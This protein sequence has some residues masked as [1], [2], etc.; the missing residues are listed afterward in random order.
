VEVLLEAIAPA[1]D[2]DDDD[3]DDEEEQAPPAGPRGGVNVRDNKG[4]TALMLALRFRRMGAAGLLLD[5]GADAGL[6]DDAGRSAL[7]YLL[8][9]TSGFWCQRR[10]G[11][12]LGPREGRR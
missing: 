8:G 2:D 6:E 3:D 1:A 11:S 5:H 12:P 4:A 10:A 9:R 7:A